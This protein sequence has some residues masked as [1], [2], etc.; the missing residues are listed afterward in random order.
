VSF[1]EPKP[2]VCSDCNQQVGGT[3]VAID[4]FPRTRSGYSELL[5]GEHGAWCHRCQRLTVY[6]V[7]G[8]A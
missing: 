7:R 5:Y 1:R 8:A 2:I 6:V 4:V 3:R